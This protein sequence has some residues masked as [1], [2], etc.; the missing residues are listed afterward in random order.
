MTSSGYDPIFP[1]STAADDRMRSFISEFYKVSDD[2]NKNE[3]WAAY[4][5]PDAVLVMGPDT[6]RGIDEI[7]KLRVK[8]WEKVAAR[9]HQPQKV[10]ESTFGSSKQGQ[11]EYMLFGDLDYDLKTGEKQSVSWAGNMVL[12]EVEGKPRFKYYRVY[13]QR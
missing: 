2:P 6:V 12:E 4:F 10:F 13:I 1:S 5:L 9:K 3:E 11:K 8:M 7:R